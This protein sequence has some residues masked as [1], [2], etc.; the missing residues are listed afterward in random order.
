MG[1]VTLVLLHQLNNGVNMKYE[2]HFVLYYLGYQ[3]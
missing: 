2:D 1:E 3:G